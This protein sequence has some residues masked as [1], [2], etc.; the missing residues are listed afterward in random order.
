MSTDKLIMP[1]KS[2]TASSSTT[3]YVRKRPS[4][5]TAVKRS[6]VT[7]RGAYTK[8]TVSKSG[9]RY[10]GVG[11]GLGTA[12]GGVLGGPAGAALGG[13]LGGLAHKALYALTGFGDYT[14]QKN[15]LLETNGPPEVLNPGGK[16]FIFRHREYITDIYSAGGAANTPSP[17]FV[18]SFPLNP[19]QVGTFPWLA[20]LAGKWEQYV[21]EGIV[22][23]YKPM[24]SDAVV[25]QNGSIGTVVLAT[26]YN[27]GAP[28]F[29]SKQQMENYQFAQSCKPSCAVIHPVE[30]ARSQ[31]V[32]SELY[33]RPSAVPVGEDIKTYD[34]GT[35]QF[36]SAGIPL[37]SAGAPVLLGELWISYQIRMLKPKI[38]TLGPASYTDS[39]YAHYSTN[40]LSA[41]SVTASAP[42]GPLGSFFG[43]P[44]NN[45]VGVSFTTN[46][47]IV[48]LQSI[49]MRYKIDVMWNGTTAANWNA[50]ATGTLTN[51]QLISPTVFTGLYI[52]PNVG[53]PVAS[54]G[55]W[56][57]FFVELPAIQGNQTQC[58]IPFQTNGTF[59]ATGTININ[60][61]VNAVPFGTI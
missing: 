48:P 42:F 39:G 21:V 20:S 24:Y 58:V 41:G 25:T 47:I 35:F 50:P 23:E 45:I 43:S 19:G 14:V 51:G 29:T 12:L 56:G 34:F 1:K 30:C 3:P 10:P 61:F 9:L 32:L 26:E 55:C 59:P 18:Q 60:V 54:S 31:T 22:V 53:A 16:S 49:P 57:C 38:P 36:A 17:F 33:V 15:V 7:G 11:A 37:G 8:K 28:A 4:T 46:S 13:A 27:A 2:A 44:A 6:Y 5:A 40:L 52:I